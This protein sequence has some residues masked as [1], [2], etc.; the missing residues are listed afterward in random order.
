MGADEGL[1]EGFGRNRVRSDWNS[2]FEQN[3]MIF[4]DPFEHDNMVISEDHLEQSQ[5]DFLNA[6]FKP[7]HMVIPPFKRPNTISHDVPFKRPNT[8]S[9]DVPFEHTNIINIE[10]SNTNYEIQSDHQGQ[11]SMNFTSSSLANSINQP[12]KES[13]QPIKPLFFASNSTIPAAPPNTSSKPFL[14]NLKTSLFSASDAIDEFMML[15]GK[16][17]SKKTMASDAIDEFMMLK[18]KHGTV[19]PDLF[20]FI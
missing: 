1:P 17:V 7:S 2:P 8:I 20:F 15:K 19:V 3:E 9:H 5:M 12:P 13:I 16:Q 10:L 4:K 14:L 6:P 18:G 11:K